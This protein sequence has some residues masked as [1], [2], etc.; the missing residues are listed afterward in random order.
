MK[1]GDFGDPPMER[2]RTKGWV[3]IQ[4]VP[5]MLRRL[6]VWLVCLTPWLLPSQA[7]AG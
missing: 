7:E 6:S 5:S 3:L 4:E 1:P 2:S